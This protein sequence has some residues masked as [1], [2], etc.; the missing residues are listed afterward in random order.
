MGRNTA[1]VRNIAASYIKSVSSRV[2]RM[3][4]DANSGN[5]R[6]TR[7]PILAFVQQATAD[8]AIPEIREYIKILN[9]KNVGF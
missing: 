3:K 9:L 5:L 7:N 6:T 4:S 2:T 1:A 8:P